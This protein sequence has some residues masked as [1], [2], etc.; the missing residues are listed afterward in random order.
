MLASLCWNFKESWNNSRW[1]RVIGEWG[2]GMMRAVDSTSLE[3]AVKRV[4]IVKINRKKM[5]EW[6]N[7]ENEI[8]AME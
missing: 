3:R 2:E 6:E 4:A 5:Q 8:L 1:E 7:A